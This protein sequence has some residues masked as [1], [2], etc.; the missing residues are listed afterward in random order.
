MLRSQL[1]LY[2][3][4]YNGHSETRD[5]AELVQCLPSLHQILGSIPSSEYNG[6]SDIACNPRI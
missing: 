1:S 6:C 4:I 2:T 3:I 5:V